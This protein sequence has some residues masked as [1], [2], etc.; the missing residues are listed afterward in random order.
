MKTTEQKT[1]QDL[2]LFTLFEG[3]EKGTGASKI[4]AQKLD[5]YLQNCAK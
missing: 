3:K 4:G 5:A 1:K 2:G